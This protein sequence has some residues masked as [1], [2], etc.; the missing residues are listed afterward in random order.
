MKSQ[1]VPN[2]AVGRLSLYLRELEQLA[3]KG[4]Q[5]VSSL[6][7]AR[8]LHVTA[9]QVR[10]DLGY[11]GQFGRPGLG[12]RVAPLIDELRHIFGTDKTWKVVVIG[13][14]ALGRAL[15]RYKGFRKKGFEL[16]AAFD[17]STRKVGKPTAEQARAFEASLTMFDEVVSSA[18]PG[19]LASE[20]VVIADKVARNAGFELWGRFLGHGVGIDVHERPDMGIEELT[21]AE[22]MTLA[23]EPRIEVGDY[24]VGHEDVVL[25]TPDGGESLNQ[26]PKQPLEL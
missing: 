24:L 6:Q 5:K 12:Y 21:L 26:F 8:E 11:F 23:I 17:V 13:V 3:D 19:V 2:P 7:L 18:K 20:L 16:V 10:K 4:V 15:L 1:S 14:G 9:A 25:V 22:N